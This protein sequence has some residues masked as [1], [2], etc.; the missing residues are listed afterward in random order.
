[1]VFVIAVS[2]VIVVVTWLAYLPALPGPFAMDDIGEIVEN[3]SIRARSL[4]PGELLH[5][6]DVP[7]WLS[8]RRPLAYVSFALNHRFFGLDSRAFRVVN[9]ALLAACGL[10]LFWWAGLLLRNW[11][12]RDQSLLAA[13]AAS[14]LW[15]VHPLQTNITSYIVQRMTSLAI[16]FYLLSFAAF[17]S[18]LRTGRRTWW[19]LTPLLAA[20]AALSKEIAWIAPASFLLC[21]AALP[22]T[23]GERWASRPRVKAAAVAAV[24]LVLGF[25]GWLSQAGFAGRPFTMGERLLT[26]GRVLWWYL[27]L[28][29]WPAPSLLSLDPDFTISKGLLSPLQTLPAALLHAGALAASLA[30]WRRHRLASLLALQ[31]YLH[32]LIEGTVLPL[33]IAFE[34][35]MSLPG[36]LLAVGAA[37]L[38]LKLCTRLVRAPRRQAV[39]FGAAVAMLAAVLATATRVRNEAW[40]SEIALWRDTAAKAPGKAR[41]HNNLGKV[42]YQAGD[43]SAA[44]A[45]YTRALQIDPGNGEALVNLGLVKFSRGDFAGALAPMEEARRRGFED[46]DLFYNMGLCLENLRRLSEALASYQRAVDGYPGLRDARVRMAGILFRRGEF[47]RARELVEGELALDPSHPEAGRLRQLL[48]AAAPRP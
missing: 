31:Y 48:Q 46:P 2:V 11:M 39:A 28:F 27:A 18:A 30:L 22:G 17:L 16:L 26:E 7:P 44:T 41:P 24:V 40:N 37:V 42:Y 35:R 20:L 6:T 36:A 5:A 32:H 4:A 21:W 43:L 47:A 33:E 8:P 3:P 12:D 19:I 34:H 14:L 38:L 29:L 15:T 25:A 1:M 10:A 13:A 9:V 23:A 45:A